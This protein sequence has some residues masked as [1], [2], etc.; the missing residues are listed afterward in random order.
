MPDFLTKTACRGRRPQRFVSARHY[1]RPDLIAKLLR[2]RHVP[3]FIVAPE[4]FGKSFVALEYAE[5]VFRFEHVFWID[6]KSPCFLRDLDDGRIAK[7]LSSEDRASFLAVVEDVP[8][9]DPQ[10]VELLSREMDALIDRGCEVLVTCLPMRDAFH[11]QRDRLKLGAADLLL[12]DVELDAL[13]TAAEREAEPAALM[14]TARRIATLAWGTSGDRAAFLASVAKEEL[15]TDLMLPLFSMLCLQSGALADLAAFGSCE[16]DSIAIL[17]EQYLYLGINCRKERFDAASF[18]MDELS[19]AFSPTL[20]DLAKRSV[21]P[22]ADALATHIADALLKREQFARACDAAR[23][24][25]SRKARAAWLASRGR[26][27]SD[28]ACLVP[29][30]DV[31]RS[32]GAEK[33]GL[34]CALDAAEAAR[35]A[36]LGD[37]DS[38]CAVARRVSG[39]SAAAVGLRAAAALVLSR[40]AEEGERRRAVRLASSLALAPEAAREDG[41]L[42]PDADWRSLAAAAAVQDALETSC[43]EGARA[44][45]AWYEGGVRGRMMAYAAAWVLSCAELE[46]RTGQSRA[47]ALPS[48]SVDQVAAVVRARV[49]TLAQNA[50]RLFDGMAGAELERACESGAVSVPSLDARSSLAVRRVE[51][52]LFSQRAE[53]ERIERERAERRFVFSTTHPD[54]FRSQSCMSAPSAAIGATPRLTVNLFGGLD[55]RIGGKRVDDALFRRQK[56][57]TLLALLVLNRGREFS[58]DKLVSLLWPESP[59]E[60]ARKNFYGVWS[61]LRRALKTPDGTCPYLIRQQRGLRLDADLLDSDVVQLD[62][63]CNKLLFEQPGYGGWA[64]LFSQVN[65]RFSDD[66]L[67][68]ENNNDALVGRRAECRDKLV[69]ALVAASTRLV[70]AGETRE[71]L[72]FARA[73]LQRD[74]GREDAYVALMEAQMGAGQRSAALETYFACRRYLVN[75]LGIDPSIETT[76]LYRSIIESEETLE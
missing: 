65:D 40:C 35:R 4:G 18:S 36:L 37:R 55:V 62:D 41:G 6:A 59:L 10:R 16:D 20:P 7:T 52:A 61:L 66:I 32:L 17:S 68:S 63:V 11:G 24:L 44:W 76:R 25:A 38:A 8:S 60:A 27:L 19:E 2:E 75:E 39:S 50:L 30:C 5:T 72:W 47:E 45:L 70:G 53:H 29:A 23:L 14:P 12:T 69:D 46:A 28:G 26:E 9:L 51:M 43:T 54:A 73:A 3:R 49:S 1:R 58:R 13:R 64:Y 56:V 67:P 74:G 42:L 15:P 71:G 33:A 31:Y 57:K 21:F 48:E 22:D 34:A